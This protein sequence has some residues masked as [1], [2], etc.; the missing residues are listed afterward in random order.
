MTH[1]AIEARHRLAKVDRGV[2]EC[3]PLTQDSYFGV[4]QVRDERGADRDAIAPHAK[5]LLRGRES[6][7]RGFDA[8][9][10]RTGLHDE[11]P[12]LHLRGFAE[13]LA[14]RGEQR[15]LGAKPVRS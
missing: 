11:A 9:E 10:R 14:L 2:D 6:G 8:R 4:E 5:R 12:N 15:L 3:E 7:A 1:L 13:L